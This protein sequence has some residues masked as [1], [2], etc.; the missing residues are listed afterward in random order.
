MIKIVA[1][2]GASHQG[3]YARCIALINA[4]R[5]AGADAV[6]LS[7]FDPDEMTA[8]S[9]ESPFIINEGVW[10]GKSLH[11]IYEESKLRYD[12]IGDL[13]NATQAAG[14][15]FIASIY[16]PNTV[17]LLKK[18]G[19]HTVKIASFELCYTELLESISNENHIRHIILSTGGATEDEIDKAISHLDCSKLTLLHCLS[20]YPAQA[21]KMNMLTIIDMKEKFGVPVGLSDHTT[22]ITAAVVATSLGASIIEKHIK[23]DDEGLDSS[24]A[25]FPDRL[26]YLVSA[27][28]EAERILGK[29][30]YSGK[31]TYHRADIDGRY[32]RKVW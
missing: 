21:D 14:L 32:L 25:V 6:K 11:Q 16:H 27:C 22:G 7:F 18:Y 4:A 23:L 2:T 28:R 1:E 10:K 29:I 19:V 15:E 20:A 8:D 12:W 9:S 30:E 26:A 24:F 3:S 13:K 5:M 17:P 31:K